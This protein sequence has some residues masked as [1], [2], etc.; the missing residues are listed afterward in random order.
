MSNFG[1]ILKEI[2]EFGLFQKRLFAALCIPSMFGSMD[3]IGQVFTGM[4]FPHHC[5]TDWILVAGPNLT[6]ERQRDLTIPVD[7]DGRF[8]SCKMFTPVDWDLETIERYGINTTTGCTDGWDYDAQP[9]ASSIVTEFDLVCGS[10]G[11]I[12]TSQS[13][14]MA[15]VLVGAFTF[16]T[17]AD[18]FGR[19]FAILLSLF[20]LLL[21][22]MST[23]LSPNIYVYM[24]LK[25]FCGSSSVVMMMNTSVMGLEW[26]TPSRSVL[27]TI[28]ITCSFSFGLMLLSGVAYLI[29]NW[30]ILQ[31][32]LFSPL[33]IVL[34]I[35][36]WYVPESARWLAT[37]GRIKE[38]QKELERVAMINGTKVPEDLLHKLKME[39][40]PESRS[41]LDIF[42]ISYLRKRTLIMA[43]NWFATSMVYYG[44]SLNVGNFGLDI[45]LT[46]LI[47][48]IVE[49][50]SNLSTMFI[51][52]SLG[53]RITQ[54][55]VL[56][57]AGIACLVILTVPNDLPV[58][59][60]LIAVL[61]K[62][63]S[64]ASFSTLYIYTAEL[65]PTVLRQNG[66]GFNSMCARTAGIL[67]PL[68]RLL[69]V[70]HYTVP[71]IIYGI[72]P[73]AACGF[74]L[75]LPETLNVQL[76]DHA[77]LKE[78]LNGPVEDKND[79]ILVAEKHGL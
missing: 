69:A 34:V 46:Q 24:V 26:S 21:S 54:A 37:Q 9:G 58:V 8:E 28:L 60:T 59:L 1:E 35:F 11:L 52:Q 65:Y 38:A 61:G 43:F 29:H 47:F 27:C 2:G 31:L 14:S 30:R 63:A 50:F 5:N 25:F 42:R 23:A 53:R 32:V 33:V 18:R 74:C 39:S 72:T 66:V 49:F 7:K 51:I 56:L 71:M 41:T 22:A 48:G 45:Y 13:I 44:L 57:L 55:S 16:G 75:L 10:K 77:T 70:Y 40:R 3:V 79:R 73:I 4:K 12:E 62:M 6:Y 64:T 68:I 19:R 15:G 36:Y 76:Q 78:P 17:I 20:L 67:A